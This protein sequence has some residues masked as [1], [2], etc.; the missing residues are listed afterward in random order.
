MATKKKVTDPVETPIENAKVA[1]VEQSAGSEAP[2]QSSDDTV[3]VDR[4]S[5]SETPQKAVDAFGRSVARKAG[6]SALKSRS[7]LCAVYVTCD[8]Q[9]FADKSDAQM[10]AA[11]LSDREVYLVKR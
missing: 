4:P 7:D 11:I 10:H 3:L 9:A 5:D 6:L 8:G 2:E 1:A